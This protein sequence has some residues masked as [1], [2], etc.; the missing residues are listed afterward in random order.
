MRNI[1]GFVF[2]WC[3]GEDVVLELEVWGLGVG[4]GGI[5]EEIFL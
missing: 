4:E 2:L 3:G 1:F 5:F